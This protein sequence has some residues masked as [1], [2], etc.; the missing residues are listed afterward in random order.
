MKSKNAKL[1]HKIFIA[2]HQSSSTSCKNSSNKLVGFVYF[3]TRT[4]DYLVVPNIRQ[5]YNTKVHNYSSTTVHRRMIMLNTFDAVHHY[6]HRRIIADV[7]VD[8]SVV[9]TAAV[10]AVAVAVVVV[11]VVVVV[12][13]VIDIT[14]C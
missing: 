10:V 6:H 5:Y 12:V 14:V 7:V 2:A 3:L 9:A 4:L 11:V 1:C 13:F 8:I